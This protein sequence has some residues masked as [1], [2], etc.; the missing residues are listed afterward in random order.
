MFEKD[1]EEVTEM[2]GLDSESIVSAV[3]RLSFLI[4]KIRASN[5]LFEEFS[6]IC[7][8]L[9]LTPSVPIIDVKTRWNSTYDMLEFAVKY[10]E[11]I[12]KCIWESTQ[13]SRNEQRLCPSADDWALI[14]YLLQMLH[15]IKEVTLMVSKKEID[16]NFVGV[17]EMI[18][19]LQ[20]VDKS[21]QESVDL[22]ELPDDD[23]LKLAIDAATEKLHYYYDNLSP[24][25]GVSLLLDPRKKLVF[26]QKMQWK[27]SWINQAMDSFKDAFSFY[28]MKTGLQKTQVDQPLPKRSKFSS[29][30]DYLDHIEPSDSNSESEVD[31]YF[32]QPAIGRKLDPLQ[33]W[34]VNAVEYPTL[35]RMARDYFSVQASSVPSERVFSSG[36]NLVTPKRCKLSPAIIEK[37]QFLKYSLSNKTV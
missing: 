12:Q 23:E 34:K 4:R 22:A 31:R 29:Y 37:T 19:L 15:P 1:D 16:N 6:A 36:A 27:P 8:A 7:R 13:L 10:K 14:Q 26:L 9:E 25:V 30:N 20:F 32:A 21:L 5:I 35:S 17:V 11:C 24:I 3:N 28:Q 18:P 33:W 2:T